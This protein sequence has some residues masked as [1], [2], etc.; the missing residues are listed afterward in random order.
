MILFDNQLGH[1]MLCQGCT[2]VLIF[3][4]VGRQ[5]QELQREMGVLLEKLQAQGQELA[6]LQ[7]HSAEATQLTA[8]LHDTSEALE[9]KQAEA[10]RAA[11]ALDDALQQLAQ[12]C[13]FPWF[14]LNPS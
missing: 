1:G 14:T 11:F 9:A 7:Q 8:V 3:E 12:A 2:S 10:Q 6:G 4:H 13:P 5:E